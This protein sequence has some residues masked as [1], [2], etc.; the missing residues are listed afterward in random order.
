MKHHSSGS[1]SIVLRVAL[2]FWLPFFPVSAAEP[3][4][5]K[6]GDFTP[7]LDIYAEAGSL[8]IAGDTLLTVYF[9]GQ[10]NLASNVQ[11]PGDPCPVLCPAYLS[12]HM[13][14]SDTTIWFDP[15]HFATSLDDLMKHHD[16][17]KKQ[18]DRL[19]IEWRKNAAFGE[20]RIVITPQI[21]QRGV[22]ATEYL[23]TPTE[24]EK[25][26]KLLQTAMDLSI[27]LEKQYGWRTNSR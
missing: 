23:L 25:L 3:H 4:H 22:R 18:F 14:N 12:F 19:V 27:W 5:V 7:K 21:R 9:Q 24:A 8:T 11:H 6:G 15:L 13:P 1:R 20:P 10:T 26:A 17:P 16:A 2:M